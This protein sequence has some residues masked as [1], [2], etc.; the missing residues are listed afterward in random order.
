MNKYRYGSYL[1]RFH[2]L[3][4][5]EEI[6]EKDLEPEEY[7]FYL[8][9]S[10]NDLSK[11][12]LTDHADP[13]LLERVGTFVRE[14]Y[15]QETK[16][17]KLHSLQQASEFDNPIPS[18]DKPNELHYLSRRNESK[19]AGDET[20]IRGLG[21]SNILNNAGVSTLMNSS[22]TESGIGSIALVYEP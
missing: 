10:K 7:V 21:C 20:H 15:N 2:H 16:S 3:Y 13:Y 19:D 14:L 5:N 22:S 12:E 4:P 17:E 6:I 8:I 11:V 1:D 9:E 18:N